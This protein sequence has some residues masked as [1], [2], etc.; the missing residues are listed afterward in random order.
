MSTNLWQFGHD[1]RRRDHMSQDPAPLPR[2]FTAQQ[3]PTAAIKSL[4][5]QYLQTDP[6]ESAHFFSISRY[7]FL[8]GSIVQHTRTYRGANQC[9][10]TAEK[11]S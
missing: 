6:T 9:F 11:Y 1:D 4:V 5:N 10:F 2:N 3:R 7:L 8:L